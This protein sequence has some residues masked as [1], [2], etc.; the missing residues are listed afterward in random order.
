MELVGTHTSVKV[1]VHYIKE[2]KLRVSLKY[3]FSMFSDY[4]FDKEDSK[5]LDFGFPLIFF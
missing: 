2:L 4:T 1:G 3:F 5:R